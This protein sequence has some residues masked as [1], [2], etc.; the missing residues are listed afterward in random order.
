MSD[1]ASSFL[2]HTRH[3]KT[4]Y[5]FA[6]HQTQ[7]TYSR[8]GL[9]FRFMH[10]VAF[11]LSA[12]STFEEVCANG[13]MAKWV[14]RKKL[15]KIIAIFNTCVRNSRACSSADVR[16]NAS[17]YKSCSANW[18]NE[19]DR[20]RQTNRVVFIF[21][22]SSLMWLFVVS[23]VDLFLLYLSHAFSSR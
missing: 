10:C 8:C 16:L 22:N 6:W 18:R 17:C 19:L 5:I 9:W 11:L 13:Q 2:L 1:G 3:T 12:F 14:F 7:I 15:H 20:K 21:L 4:F 23:V